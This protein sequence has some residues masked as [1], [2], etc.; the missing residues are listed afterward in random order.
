MNA[1]SV[2]TGEKAVETY[3]RITEAFKHGFSVRTNLGDMDQETQEDKDTILEV[4]K[5]I[6]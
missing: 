4:C 5:S 3:H 2:S 1:D 6:C